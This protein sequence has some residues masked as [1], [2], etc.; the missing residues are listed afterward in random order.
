MN[1]DFWWFEYAHFACVLET[2]GDS[3]LQHFYGAVVHCF[4][5]FSWFVEYDDGLGL[6][7]KYDVMEASKLRLR[8]PVI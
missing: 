4:D 3:I 7:A 6:V 8:P 5:I 1:D 2:E